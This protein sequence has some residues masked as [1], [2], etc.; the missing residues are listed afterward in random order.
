MVGGNFFE[1][2]GTQAHVKKLWKMFF[3]KRITLTMDPMSIALLN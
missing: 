1:V 2:G 3:N